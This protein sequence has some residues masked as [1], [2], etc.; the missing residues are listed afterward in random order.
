MRSRQGPARRQPIALI[1][2]GLLAAGQSA[3]AVIDVSDAT[4]LRDAII[5]ANSAPDTINITADITL[6]S[7]L[8]PISNSYTIEGNGHTVS[9][10]GVVRVFVLRSGDI[11]LNNMVIANGY[12]TGGAGGNI[13]GGG[14][15]AGL[16]GGLL[17]MDGSAS[18]TDVSFQGNSAQAGL[19]ADFTAATNIGGGGGGGIDSAGGSSATA[20]FLDGGGGGGGGGL[21][22]PGAQNTNQFGG[23]GGDPN[24]GT[25]GAGYSQPGGSG[26]FG[27]G[28][29]GGSGSSEPGGGGSGGNG[30]DF[31]GGGGGGSGY[32]YSTATSPY[33]GY[34][35]GNGGDGGFGGG[36]GAGGAGYENY[37]GSGGNGGNGGDGGFGGGGGAGGPGGVGETANGNSGT[38][39]SGGLYGQDAIAGSGGDG[40][41]LGGALFVRN[42]T[43]TLRD[44]S[45]S[46]NL[47]DNDSGGG[48]AYG[49]AIATCEEDASCSPVVSGCGLSFSG[50]TASSGSGT[51]T[52]DPVNN[53]TGAH[54]ND[55]LGTI[56][57]I[58]S[59]TVLD[60][61]PLPSPP[62]PPVAA[63]TGSATDPSAIPTLG[64]G[65][66]AL[67]AA[68]LSA[69]GIGGLRR[70]RRMH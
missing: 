29:G 37:S 13:R 46:G 21:D 64:G 10:G 18:L 16:G 48:Q 62:A 24:P 15:G 23:S 39:G 47:A 7:A 54:N 49:A 67:L 33:P 26:G 28:G 44:V 22:S 5:S 2:A 31:A 20:A 27:G 19:G 30:G 1:S 56:T 34:P 60:A 6:T 55:L 65:M 32:G 51:I 25:A 50:N 3:H 17:V 8:P 4:Q 58:G 59:G 69:L 12:A 63:P 42:G 38:G 66:L 40:A 53:V 41:A 57:P 36:G 11:V 70:K 45:F 14:G 52:A 68:T 43:V 9:G 35:G 61:C